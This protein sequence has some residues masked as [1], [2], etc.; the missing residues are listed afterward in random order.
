MTEATPI[1]TAPGVR[2]AGGN[3]DASRSETGGARPRSG[4][5]FRA[6]LRGRGPGEEVQDRRDLRLFRPARRR[7]LQPARARRQ[8]HD[9][10][11]HPEGPGRGLHDRGDLRRRAEQARGRHQRSRPPDRAGKGG[12]A[13]RLLLLRTVRAGGRPG[14]AARQVHVDHHLHLH[15]RAGEPQLQERLPAAGDGPAFRH[16][17]YRHDRLLL[18]GEVRQG[19]EGPSRGDHPRRWRLRRGRRP[20][21]RGRRQEAQPE[22]G[23]EGRLCRH[24]ARSLGAGHQAA[25]RPARRDPAH[26]LQPGHLAVPAPGARGRAEVRRL[27][28]ALGSQ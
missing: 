13:A 27:S 10:P 14:G 25:P 26:R 1:I 17:R 22:R 21:Q 3:Q 7:R 24:R 5:G 11:L 23:A 15:R 19:A 18:Q 9:R 16:D 6:R 12:H 20:R 28:L 8:D 4:S 2:A